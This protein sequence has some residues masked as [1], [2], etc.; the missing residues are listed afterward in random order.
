MILQRDTRLLPEIR[1]QGCYYMCIL[2]FI[3][4][5]TNYPWTPNE[6]NE[7]YKTMVHIGAIQADGDFTTVDADD[8]TIINPSK[9]FALKGLRV[10]YN[11][12]HDKPS[13]ICRPN[14]FE[15]LKFVNGL[16]GHFVCGNGMG[17]P[18]YDPY[19]TSKTVELGYLQSK[20]IFRRL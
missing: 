17:V 10:L 15:I 9:I 13:Y 19:G 7:F 1:E 16:T 12:R 11:N 2:F 18:T 3:N 6:I 5:Y 14:E 20:R 4:K 8:S